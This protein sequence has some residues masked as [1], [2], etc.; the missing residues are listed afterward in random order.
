MTRHAGHGRSALERWGRFVATH[1]RRLL[2]GWLV[3]V[4]AGFAVALGGL[5]TPSLFDR[6]DT[7]EIVVDGENRSGRAVL[8]EAGGS[9]FGTR[10]LLV[11]GVDI[12]D[13]A[14]ARAAATAVRDLGAVDGVR[15]AVNP[16]VVPDGPTSAAARPML[17]RGDPAAGGFATVVT[18][19]PDVTAEQED[20]ATPAVDAVF[21]RLVR[22][23]GATSS[24]RGG[25]AGLV[26]RIVEQVR[27]DGQRGEGIALPVSFAVMVVVFGG[28]LAAGFPVLGAIASIAG[29][30]AS[31][32]GFSYLLDLDATAVNVVTVLALG[33]CIDYGLLVV[34]RFREEMRTLLAGRP[35]AE[36]TPEEVA[37]ATGR[38]LDRA[39]RTVVF[40]A[41][42][43]AISLAGLLLLEIDFV[44]AVSLAGVSVVVVAMAVALS[45]VPALCV[46]GARRLLRRGTEVGSDT[47]VFSRLAESVH[48]VPWLVI[49]VVSALLVV[50]AAPVGGM[51][52]TSSGA[53][54][55]PKGTPERTFFEDFADGYP[56]LSGAQ[57]VLVAKAPEADVRAWA[58]DAADRPGVETVDPVRVLDGGVATV[59]FHTGDSGT[60]EASRALVDS[61]RADR[62]PFESWVVGQA[63]GILDFRQ[64]VADRAP[65]AIGAVVLATL[66]L[67][68]L[69]TGSVVVPVKALVMNVLS[70]GASLGVVVWIFQEG[71]LEGLLRFT[72]AGGLENTIPLLVV[73]FGFGLS[74]DYEVF[75]LSRIVELHEQGRSTHEAVVLGLQRSGRII[76]SAALLMVIVFSGFAAGDLLVMKQMGVALVLAITIDAT[77]VRMLL[78]PATMAVLGRANWWAPA[79]LRRLHARVGITE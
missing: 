3:F 24:E 37:T 32:L 74:M 52:L 39:G 78:V 61:L 35:A 62:P 63:S 42:T 10:T 60:G 5:G 12:T 44:R 30:L 79:P 68:F 20:A 9:A 45:L 22:D 49:G 34:S 40:S 43:V 15:S 23:T 65:W 28:F 51:L 64:A 33:L 19:A 55:L 76:T 16:F 66:V 54:L 2:L 8:T 67:L 17:L 29:A 27:V 36:A 7:G 70:L 59:P 50:L 13:P 58:Q 4:V 69:M 75:L 1:A 73:A 57:V 38:T 46:L 18:F 77:L 14:V 26:D 53:E 21:D 47:G 31:L 11:E 25:L 41:I 71:H 56:T 72:S 6:L 48:R